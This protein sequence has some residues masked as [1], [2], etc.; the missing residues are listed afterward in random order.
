[1]KV[2]LAD[3]EA[4][5]PFELFDE[6]RQGFVPFGRVRVGEVDEVT[7]VR[8]DMGEPIKVVA[9]PVLWSRSHDFFTLAC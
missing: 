1:M 2:E 4:F 8:D 7:S 9:S 5:G 6:R 3:S